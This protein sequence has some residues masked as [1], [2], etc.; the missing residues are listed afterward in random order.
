MLASVD[1]GLA[2]AICHPVVSGVDWPGCPRLE[3][4]SQEVG[5]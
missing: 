1:Y 5:V 2:L 4:T 3:Q